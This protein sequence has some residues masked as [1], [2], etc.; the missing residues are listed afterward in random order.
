MAILGGIDPTAPDLIEHRI[1]KRRL[2]LEALGAMPL[3][4]PLDGLLD[5]VAGTGRIEVF[6]MENVPVDVR[7]LAPEQIAEA[8]DRVFPDRDEEVRT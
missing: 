8:G 6:E 1:D 3:V 5:R 2:D 4:Q 7:C